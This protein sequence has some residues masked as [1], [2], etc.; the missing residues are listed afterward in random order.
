MRSATRLWLGVV[1]VAAVVGAWAYRHSRQAPHQMVES[2]ADDSPDMIVGEPIRFQNLT[3]FPV[4][5]KVAKDENRF[6]TF[7]E[8]LKSGL[9]SISEVGVQRGDVQDDA[10]A[11]D[12]DVN[13]LLVTN[14][15]D[16][17]LYLMPGEILV[18][19]QQDRA[20][21]DELVVA[22]HTERM[23][24]NVFCV[25]HGRWSP[26]MNEESVQLA[27]EVSGSDVSADSPR[28]SVWRT[29]DG[30]FSAAGG[31]LHKDG[32]LT[33][34]SGKGQTEVWDEISDFNDKSGVHTS[35]G[36]FTANYCEPEVASK[37]Q[38]YIAALEKAIAE[39]S[40]VVGVI[41]AVN[42]EIQAA[43]TFE[44]TPLFRKLWPKLLESYVLDAAMRVDGDGDRV[45]ECNVAQAEAFLRDAMEAKVAEI[46]DRDGLIT[47]RG[48]GQS[49][50]SFSLHESRAD[51]Q[52]SDRVT[53]TNNPT[54]DA[55]GMGGMGGGMGGFGGGVHS[56][57]FA[58]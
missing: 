17:P 15:S 3:I 53:R 21:A 39:K 36:A 52:V 19:G 55:K 4:T 33:V 6:I 2:T 16:Q 47:T 20:V 27:L 48:D 14:N 31:Y 7:A 57:A 26:R 32:R 25:E 24:I 46:S 13:Q 18:G 56:A 10:F 45:D 37:L 34:Q 12:G 51:N 11:V 1:V 58:H 8:G 49:L 38:P 22:P 41:V 50:A 9:V 40:R 35:S 30:A 44:S 28:A 43:D 54:G 5:S 29:V 42:D 23:P